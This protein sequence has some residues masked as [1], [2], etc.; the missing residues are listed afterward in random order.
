[1]G[2]CYS[3][4]KLVCDLCGTAGARKVPCPF[5]YCPSTAVCPACRKDPAKS[6]KLAK[7]HHAARGCEAGMARVRAE[8]AKRAALLAAGH[9]LRVAAFGPRGD[10]KVTFRNAAGAERSVMMAP[11]VYDAFPLG[12]PVTLADYEAKAAEFGSAVTPVAA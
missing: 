11:A 8:S 5:G 2:F 1:M 10:V 6:A 7:A 4:R 3:G 12:A 9:W